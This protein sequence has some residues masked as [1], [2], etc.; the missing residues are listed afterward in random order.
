MAQYHYGLTTSLSKEEFTRRKQFL[1]RLIAQLEKRLENA[2]NGSLVVNRKART[3]HL[4][5]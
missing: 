4:S 3:T 2:P 5:R 1:E